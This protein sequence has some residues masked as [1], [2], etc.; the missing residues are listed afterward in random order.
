MT[1]S[2]KMDSNW[3]EPCDHFG[4]CPVCKKQD[5]YIN[6]GRGHWFFCH[7]HKKVWF[8]GSN[9]FSDWR[10]EDEMTQINNFEQINDYEGWR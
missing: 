2:M 4:V 8:A 10:D 3:E 7:E 5:G 6:V 1:T 9:L